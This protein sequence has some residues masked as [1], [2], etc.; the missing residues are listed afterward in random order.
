MNAGL[1]SRQGWAELESQRSM[2]TESAMAASAPN[3]A[4]VRQGSLLDHEGGSP[5]GG[6]TPTYRDSVGAALGRNNVYDIP[7]DD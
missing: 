3:S 7:A 2:G 1:V 4:A 5:D 6:A